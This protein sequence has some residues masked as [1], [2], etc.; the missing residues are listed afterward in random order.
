M[1]ILQ[2]DIQTKN[3]NDLAELSD[4]RKV[5]RL[6]V[7]SL[8]I[9]FGG[10][11]AWAGLVPLDQGVPA[12]GVLIVDTKRKAVQHLTGGMISQVLVREGQEV[13]A[14]QTLITLDDN[15][16][17]AEY[18]SVRQKYIELKITYAR[19]L[20]ELTGDLNIKFDQEILREADL[21]SSIFEQMQNEQRLMSSR[22]SVLNARLDELSEISI[23]QQDIIRSSERIDSNLF[24]QKSNLENELYG[25]KR[26]VQE[27]FAPLMRQHEIEQ[28]I[29][30]LENQII[31][32]SSNKN[33]AR[34]DL[35]ALNQQIVGLKATY[36]QDVEQSLA[37]IRP[38]FYALSERYKSIGRNVARLDIP[39]P[40]KGRVVGLS[41]QTVGSVIS[42]GQLLMDIVPDDEELTIEAK[43]SPQFID[44]IKE[45]DA[46]DVR[47]SSFAN[48]PQLVVPGM[49]ASLSAD[50][51][52]DQRAGAQSPGFYLARVRLNT[53]A[54]AIL[55]RRKLQP[56]MNVEV[57][58]K[59]G[60]RTLLTYLLHPLLKRVA[61]ALK[62]E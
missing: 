30:G 38:E 23:S 32:N 36:Q 24:D 43:I 8:I 3:S 51:I 39:A 56:G 22:K 44:S 50:T 61:I 20:S 48:T 5:S 21:D 26:L 16:A 15:S 9:G 19:L 49:L 13:E 57:V 11:F 33:R 45:G 59:T 27:G 31:E 2:N 7:W 55:G 6:A 62:E 37:R 53:E 60:R 34:Q 14:G 42:P 47:F 1:N 17:R 25:I 58:V 52:L 28:R 12:A 10:F 4:T 35:A 18:E 29:I 46:V 41:V 40:V 54:Y